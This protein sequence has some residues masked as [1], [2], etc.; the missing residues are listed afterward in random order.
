[1]ANC[2]TLA[3]AR[4][5]ARLKP[6]R[7]APGLQAVRQMGLLAD[8][9]PLLRD[10]GGEGMRCLRRIGFALRRDEGIRCPADGVP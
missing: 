3:Q 5:P 9:E 10:G 6:C 8:G 1:M 2:V 4:G 7:G